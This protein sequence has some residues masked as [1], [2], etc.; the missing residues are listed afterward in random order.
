MEVFEKLGIKIPNAVLV[1]RVTD[2]S[3]YEEVID[4]LERYGDIEQN[5][6]ID[7]PESEFHDSFVVEFTSDSPLLRMS[8]MLPYTH[9]SDEGDKFYIENL[10]TVYASKVGGLKTDTYLADL[11]IIAKCS[12][13][14]Y[15]DV[16]QVMMS[17]INQSIAQLRL[18]VGTTNANSQ[19]QT[20]DDPMKQFESPR[21]APF[22][23][24]GIQGASAVRQP[25]IP[26]AASDLNPPEVQ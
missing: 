12:G 14:E 7:H 23:S 26:M 5:A 21:G 13:K 22:S 8:P 9:V 3:S 15:T 4:F 19:Q 1:V 11:K 16:L 20:S 17:Q 25:S 6:T 24:G 18:P 10:S 2:S